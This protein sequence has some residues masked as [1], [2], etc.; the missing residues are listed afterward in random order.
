MDN[1]ESSP[2]LPTYLRRLGLEF[3]PFPVTPDAS[4]YFLSSKTERCL[5]ELLHCIETRKGFLLVTGD[6]GKGKTTLSRRLISMLKE[7]GT[8]VSLV[9]N[10]FLHGESLLSA[11]NHDFGL[12]HVEGISDQLRVLNEHLVGLYQQGKNCVIIIDDSQHLDVQSLEL[13]RQI[14]N[15][16]TNQTKLVQIVLIAQPEILTTLNFSEIRQLKS[17]IALHVQ[18]TSFNETEVQDYISYRLNAAGHGGRIQ[19]TRAAL[20]LLTSASN[21]TPR[22]INLIMDRCLYILSVSSEFKITESAMKKAVADLGWLQPTSERPKIYLLGAAAVVLAALLWPLG[23]FEKIKHDVEWAKAA[24]HLPAQQTDAA[25]PQSVTIPPKEEI[26]DSTSPASTDLPERDNS[27]VERESQPTQSLAASQETVTNSTA[28]EAVEQETVAEKS[29]LVSSF[30]EDKPTLDPVSEPVK[31]AALEAQQAPAQ[32]DMA[33]SIEDSHARE[34]LKLYGLED[35]YPAFI[36][37]VYGDFLPLF[38]RELVDTPWRLI[39]SERPLESNQV[40]SA[41]YETPSKLTKTRWLFLWQPVLNLDN[42]VYGEYSEDVEKLQSALA[43]KGFYQANIDGVVGSGTKV[44]IARFQKAIGLPATGEPD[45]LT[46][47]QLTLLQNDSI[48]N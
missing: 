10:S 31:V 23:G 40:S 17:R 34:F 1:T 36:E 11:I 13:V 30:V 9:F 3:N 37:A 47:S 6:V 44:A 42:W 20:K 41:V 14:S 29:A 38:E 21:G 25:K 18:L 35:K 48:Q 32:V 24:F 19:V 16:E 15:L 27:V 46:L 5:M 22:R 7:E 12:P 26:I 8:Q 4:H 2:N 45:L 28:S 43:D 33:I 39:V